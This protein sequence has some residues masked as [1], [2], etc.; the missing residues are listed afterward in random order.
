VSDFD[1]INMYKY[2]SEEFFANEK[3]REMSEQNKE[4]R[5]ANDIWD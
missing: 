3:R 4:V 1:V 5:I 2:S